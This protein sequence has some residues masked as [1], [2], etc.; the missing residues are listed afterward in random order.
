MC[1]SKRK[2]SL[3]GVSDLTHTHYPAGTRVPT[4]A[5]E[6]EG[7][8]VGERSKAATEAFKKNHLELGD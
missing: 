4:D 7:R 2:L 8:L 5:M 1:N 3:K 6:D